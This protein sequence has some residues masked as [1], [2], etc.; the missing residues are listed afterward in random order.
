M[1]LESKHGNFEET[2]ENGFNAH[3]PKKTLNFC[4]EIRNLMLIKIFTKPL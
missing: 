3:V 4:V 2:L 1:D